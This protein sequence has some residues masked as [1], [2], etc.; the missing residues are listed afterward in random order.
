MV[1]NQA[2]IMEASKRL[3]KVALIGA[4]NAGKSTL[5]NRLIMS[6]ISCVSNKVHTTRKNILAAY[7]EGNTQLEFYDSPGLV[8]REHLLKHHL[9]DNMATDPVEAAHKCDL[10]GVVVDVSNPRDQRRLN[11]G[12]LRILNEHVDKES[13]LI[14][15]KVDLV[16]E[17]RHLLDIGAKLSGGHIRG[18]PVMRSSQL[19][20]LMYERNKNRRNYQPTSKYV[21]ELDEQSPSDTNDNR[22]EEQ[23]YYEHFSQIFSISA[24]QDD[25]VDDLRENMLDMAKP[26]EKWPHGADFLTTQNSKEVIN[27]IIRGKVMDYTDNHVPYVVQYKYERV[28]H[29]E[30]GSLHIHLVLKV[31]DRYIVGRV[32]GERGAIISSITNE[33]REMIS[34]IL[35]CDVKLSIEV[36]AKKT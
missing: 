6:D 9:G 5:L 28:E 10:I 16:K 18:K 15:N 20:N 33:S 13:F 7:T 11:K 19:E 26:V 24:L 4:P 25:G 27:N 23:E 8:T 17:K 2:S 14:M 21:I 32:I 34:K 3:L 30:L 1:I 22:R 35:G 31:P 12:L 29:D 36:R